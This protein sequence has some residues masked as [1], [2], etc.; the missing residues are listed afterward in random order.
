MKKTLFAIMALA[1]A[2]TGCSGSDP[3][4]PEKPKEVKVTGIS[5]DKTGIE[6]VEGETTTLTATVT[7]SDATDK[8]ITWASNAPGI[9]EVNDNGK[10]TAIKAGEATIT[11]TTKDGGKT[12]TCKIT[13]KAATIAVTGV[14]LDK[15]DISLEI[16]KS[17][18]L[19]ATV[20]PAEATN[21]NV[22]WSSDKPEIASVDAAGKVTGVSIGEATITVTTEDGGKTATCKVKVKGVLVT[23][24]SVPARAIPIGGK[25]TLTAT[26]LPENAN[27]SVTWSSE[28][29]AI[30][31]VD[32]ATGEV[33]GIAIGT[34]KITAT[35]NDGSGVS[36]SGTLTVISRVKSISINPSSV[37]VKKGNSTTLV[38]TVTPVDGVTIDTGVTWSSSDESIA[39]VDA[40][41]K[42]TGLAVGT[43]TITAI[44]KEDTSKKATCTF[45]VS[46]DGSAIG[47]YGGYEEEIW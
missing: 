45:K 42:V 3:E 16:G 26:V 36:G 35:A 1:V 6:M 34:V 18:E 27:K 32:P 13:V 20:L 40:G 8:S 30:A 19:A 46:E 47:D 5:L 17:E 29:A 28:N 7:P 12:A 23:S 11:A 31:T 10:V 22:T 21:K 43:V 41:G 39:T 15:T 44:S 4:E 14:T 38:A 2:F 37:T 33:T 25:T 9:A 24:I